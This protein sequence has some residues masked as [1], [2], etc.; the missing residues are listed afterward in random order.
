MISAVVK[1]EPETGYLKDE[2]DTN[3]TYEQKNYFL[4]S[5]EEF[6]KRKQ[7]LQ[8][9]ENSPGYKAYSKSSIATTRK[10][11]DGAIVAARRTVSPSIR[12]PALTRLRWIWRLAGSYHLT[13]TTHRLMAEAAQ[14]F[15]SMGHNR[16][17][18]WAVQKADE[19]RGHDQLALLDIRSIGYEA[20]AVVEALIP[21]AAMALVDY[22]S[23]SV[24]GL[25]PIG[26]V[27]Y[28]YTIER[29]AAGVREEHIQAV[30]AL[31]PAGIQATRCLRVH[32]GIGADL[33]HVEETVKMVTGLNP[34]EHVDVAA[35]CYETALLC[36][37]PPK[38]GYISEE[39]LHYILNPLKATHAEADSSDFLHHL[40][41]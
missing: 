19:E 3:R 8:S 6:L 16:L 1:P 27:G 14:K 9:I 40:L 37:S 18:Q 15:T 28:S 22:F 10:L 20:E 35:A 13:H 11:L 26:C 25:N 17:A 12:P 36:F 34:E 23:Q 32:S 2:I 21:P 41:R 29:L 39:E 4:K 30:E 7:P 38:D 33:E 24:Q 5:L 31:M